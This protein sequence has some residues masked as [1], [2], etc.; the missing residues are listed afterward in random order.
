M[1]SPL[2]PIVANLFMENFEKKAIDSYPL[3][4]KM[5]K[6]YVDDTNVLWP[7]GEQELN[8][9][10]E[11]LNSQSVDIKFTM[12]VEKNGSIPFLDVL[13]YKKTDGY[14]GHK[15]FRKKTHTDSY[16][17]ADSHHH[18]AQKLGII[19]T[20]ATRA[21]RICDAEHLKEEQ[22]NLVRVFKNIGYK[23]NDIRRTLRKPVGILKNPQQRKDKKRAYL[24]Y[25]Q[26]V[27]D[28]VSKVLKKKDILTAFKPLVTIR[29]KMRTV[30]DKVEEHQRKGVYKVTCSCGLNYIGET[31]RSLKVRLREHGADIRNQRIHTSALAEHSERSK[32]HICLEE[33]SLL[34]QENHYFKRRFREA[35]EIIKHPNNLNRDGG[36]EVSK[37]WVPLIKCL[38][39]S[40]LSKP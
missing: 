26:G 9:F 7:Y 31:G 11:H 30:K 34:A 37:S 40:N 20:L 27:T 33:A 1:G 39:K 25:I 23:E 32:H 2:S 29:Q 17:E 3:K 22:G 14:L 19:N 10:F 24:P 13:V 12:E 36:F 16:L 38:N 5:W 4:P 28:K 8:K 21:S 35:I 6:R 18:P 15:V